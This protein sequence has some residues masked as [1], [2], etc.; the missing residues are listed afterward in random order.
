MDKHSTETNKR[1][2]RDGLEALTDNNKP[3]IVSCIDSYHPISGLINKLKS[4]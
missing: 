3:L 4:Y 1:R 2:I